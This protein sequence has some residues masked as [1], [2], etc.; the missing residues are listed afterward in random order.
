MYVICK[1]ATRD[2]HSLLVQDK[3]A[4]DDLAMLR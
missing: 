1:V 3:M 2:G 4:D